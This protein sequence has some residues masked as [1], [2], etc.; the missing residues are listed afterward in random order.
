MNDPGA[1]R[2][3]LYRIWKVRCPSSWQPTAW[4]ELPPTAL[5]LEPA[6]PGALSAED[7]RTYLA[8]F[9]QAVLTERKR[10]WALAVPIH[11][12]YEGDLRA[13]DRLNRAELSL[14]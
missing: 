6:E 7:A 1:P 8:G 12:A 3:Q 9:N 14:P 10:L 11:V 5:A 2:S 4:D 13:G